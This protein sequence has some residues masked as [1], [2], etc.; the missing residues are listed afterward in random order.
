M[1]LLVK[2]RTLW[3]LC[4]VH[5]PMAG[6]RGGPRVGWPLSLPGALPF[7]SGLRKLASCRAPQR[8]TLLGRGFTR[9]AGPRMRTRRTRSC[10][11]LGDLACVRVW[12]DLLPRVAAA[13]RGIRLQSANHAFV[14]CPRTPTA[15]VRGLRASGLPTLPDWRHSG[16][17]P[18][19]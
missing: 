6:D 18:R 15:T 3:H 5:S 14:D 13:P 19:D 10:R 16:V 1:A 12:P 4:T 7:R 11:R 17:S 2:L 9:C 8:R